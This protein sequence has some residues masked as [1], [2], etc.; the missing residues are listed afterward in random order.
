MSE[1]SKS[2]M[3]RLTIEPSKSPNHQD[4]QQRTF[5]RSAP[6]SGVRFPFAPYVGPRTLIADAE[7]Y[8]CTALRQGAIRFVAED[9]GRVV[10]WCDIT[11]RQ[12][13]GCSHIGQLSMGLLHEY[14]GQVSVIAFSTPPCVKLSAKA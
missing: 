13:P 12:Q 4:N 7:R 10:G 14:R 8:L 6:E 2:A 1:K 11:P 5:R 9:D 3:R